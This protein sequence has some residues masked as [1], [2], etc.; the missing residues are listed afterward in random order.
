M[1]KS[2]TGKSLD[3]LKFTWNK[4]LLLVEYLSY[5]PARKQGGQILQ[6]LLKTLPRL[7]TCIISFLYIYH[8]L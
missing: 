1:Q 8:H 4:S 3:A 6:V 2:Q 7:A 5:S